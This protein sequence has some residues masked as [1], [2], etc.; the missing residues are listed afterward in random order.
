M[1][2]PTESYGP[3]SFGVPAFRVPRGAWNGR[4]MGEPSTHLKIPEEFEQTCVPD[5]VQVLRTE[6]I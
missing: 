1:H 3:G 6:G 4:Q 5:L 2:P